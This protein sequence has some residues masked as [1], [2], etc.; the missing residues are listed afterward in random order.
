MSIAV[1]DPF[2]AMADP[3]LPTLALALNPALARHEF[4]RRLP[5]LS[6]DGKLR[7][8][9]I[10]VVRHKPGRR[11]IVEYDVE[12]RRPGVEHELVTLIGKVRARRSGNE[13]FRQLEILWNAGFHGLSADGVSVPEPIGVI[14]AFK[15][16]FQRKVPGQRSETLFA[17]AEGIRLA[18]RVAEAIHKLHATN[19]PADRQ[20]TM[21]DELRILSVCFE[22]VIVAKPDWASRILRLR[23]A[24]ERLGASLPA[25]K[26]CGI[27]RDFYP[28][29]VIVDG[30][31]LWLIDFDLFCEGDPGLDVGNFIGHMIESSLRA[32][33]DANATRA[34]EQT[35]EERFVEL[36]G[37]AV[38]AS[39]H[40]YT[41]LTLA[42]HIYLSTQFPER[43][44]VT[45]G[46]LALCEKRLDF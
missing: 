42:R 34:Q 44:R 29:Q 43:Q 8:R 12:L 35:L 46:L 32:T 18:R 27:H 21:A 16:W 1:N 40:V 30:E 45:E 17:G 11:C 39:V 4:K 20:H 14:S 15:M 28:A 31:R 37:E 36:S 10:R 5:R 6:G 25:P 2:G 41:T 38:R 19:I 3:A 24:C 7:L 23:A 13:G 33:G 22:K 9:A 26:L